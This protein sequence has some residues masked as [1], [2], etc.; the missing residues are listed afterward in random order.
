MGA[1]GIVV[2]PGQG[3][4]S[5]TTPGREFALKLLGG[6]TGDSIMIFEE[7][8]PAGTKSTLHLHHDSDEVAYVLSGEV[9][10]MI[11][12]EVTVGGAGAYA[13][14]P[15]GVP[16][17]WKSTGADTGRVLFLYTPAKA[18]GL[19]EEQH[20]TQRNFAS[21]TEREL[22]ETLQRHGWELLGPSPL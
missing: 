18:G 13:F 12:D 17:A 14:M 22:S 11:G 21:M 4:V 6:A 1:Q 8:V 9:T 2:Q 7:T 20:R 19:I 15:R 16:H 5:S 3:Q 10:F